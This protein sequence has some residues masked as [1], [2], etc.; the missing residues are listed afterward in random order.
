[1]SELVAPIAL[2]PGDVTP[3]Y[4]VLGTPDPQLYTIMVQS[5]DGEIVIREWES[6]RFIEP[7]VERVAHISSAAP[8]HHRDA[9]L[10]RQAQ[11]LWDAG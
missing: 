11:K 10:F 5:K 2:N 6:T 7:S 1:M 4:L 9:D 3:D 8:I